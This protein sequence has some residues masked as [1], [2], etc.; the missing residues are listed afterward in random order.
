MLKLKISKGEK[1]QIKQWLLD[2]FQAASDFD[3]SEHSE[4]KLY[5]PLDLFDNFCR[6][7][8]DGEQSNEMEVK[9]AKVAF[10]E[11]PI[12]M[13]E[14]IDGF[15]DIVSGFYK[16]LS[17]KTTD[18]SDIWD[19]IK[20]GGG[21]VH[22]SDKVFVKTDGGNLQDAKSSKPS[23]YEVRTEPRLALLMAHLRNDGV[24]G[25]PIYMDDLAITKGKV[26]KDMMREHPYNIVQIPRIN[27]E[28]AVCE[29]IGETTFVKQGCIEE[30]FWDYLK[31][32]ELKARA[33][34]LDVTRRSD[35]QWWGEISSFLEGNAKPEAKK[36]NVKSWVKKKPNLDRELIKESLLAHYL[37]TGEPL[38]STDEEEG[39]KA[40]SYK[41]EHGYY[42]GKET[43]K[44]ID[45]ALVTDGQRG[46]KGKSSIAKLNKE[47]AKENGFDYFNHKNQDD[48][49]IE[50]IKES[51]LA[52]YKATGRWLS[53]RNTAK[54]QKCGSYELEHGYYAGKETVRSIEN[55]L[56]TDG[57]RGLKGKSSIAQLKKELKAELAQEQGLDNT[58]ALDL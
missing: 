4:A 21:I 53:V 55:A 50:L 54:G 6:V 12:D 34:V 52:H 2:A 38:N 57:Q 40:G 16:R 8:N 47:I 9:V 23:S 14:N 11:H 49:D 58:V 7:N 20:N 1:T 5:D 13:P 41:L 32:D 26:S 28:I 33:D 36:V 45:S 22:D 43:V 3:G 35:R 29:Q 56:V 17:S 25:T 30:D 48:L 51:L 19:V 37:A 15:L 39:S 46:L 31:K 42:A 10:P 44:S 27:M 18:N 24:N